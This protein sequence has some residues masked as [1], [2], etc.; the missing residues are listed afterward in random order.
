VTIE[1]IEDQGDAEFVCVSRLSLPFMA[2]S[3]AIQGKY[4]V[5]KY[6]R[7]QAIRYPLKMILT[8]TTVPAKSS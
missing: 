6:F 8:A 2:I 1:R 4:L 5:G 3:L 7:K